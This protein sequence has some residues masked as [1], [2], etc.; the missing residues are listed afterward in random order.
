MG[1]TTTL[2]D[3][4][5]RCYAACLCSSGYPHEVAKC[6]VNRALTSWS[7]HRPAFRVFCDTP[8]QV[9]ER[10]CMVPDISVVSS[11]RIAPGSAGIF[12]GVPELAIE[13]VSSELAD[14]LEGKIDLYFSNGGK[15]FWT[16]YPHKRTVRI[17]DAAGGSNRFLHDQAL[18][19]PSILPGF[20]IP[21]SAIFQGV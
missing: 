3:T 12:Q 2:E 1:A 14:S 13:V 17:H 10:N 6:N 7:L 8:F 9:H 19:D 18:L 15:S 21:T 11:V 20:S 4:V 5:C 16:V